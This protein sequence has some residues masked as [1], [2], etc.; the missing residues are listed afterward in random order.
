MKK[1][2]LLLLCM[3]TLIMAGCGD[4]FAKEKEAI[5]KAE[6]DAMAMQLPVM[7]KPDD[8]KQPRPSQQEYAKYQAG[9]DQ[10]IAAET[11][12][13][14]EM[15]KS[16]AQIAQMLKKASDESEKKDVLAF[17]DKVRQDRINF[18]KKISRGRLSGDP[19]IVGVGS[20]WEEVEMV[21][22]KP[23]STGKEF[24]GAK[25]YDYKGLKFES[26]I[27][28]GVP[29]LEVR[30]K[31]KSKTV[32]CATMTS[33]NIASDAGIRIGMPRDEVYKILKSKYVNKTYNPQRDAMKID[34]IKSGKDDENEVLVQYAM[35]ETEP[36]LMFLDFENGRLVRYA[37]APN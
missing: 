25:E 26:W 23:V 4:K 27:G 35:K 29:P 18:V 37:A 8:W 22:G 32:M 30:K 5:T 7:T 12:I 15:N 9:L 17:R 28:G 31:W 6:K 21:Y 13:L 2:L 34:K 16:D 36:Y 14:A 24:I 20:T 10:L 33:G 11:K 1:I 3:T 19:F